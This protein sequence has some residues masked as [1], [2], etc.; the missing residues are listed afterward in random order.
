LYRLIDRYASQ[1]RKKGIPFEQFQCR[2]EK[3]GKYLAE[4]VRTPHLA[5]KIA[6]YALDKV[7]TLAKDLGL[8]YYVGHGLGMHILRYTWRQNRTSCHL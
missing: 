2:V 7:G 3:V 5:D 1:Q 8:P 6:L 4:S